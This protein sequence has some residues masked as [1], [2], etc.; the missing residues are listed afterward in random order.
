MV[1]ASRIDGFQ[2]GRLDCREREPAIQGRDRMILRILLFLLCTAFFQWG[3][4]RLADNWNLAP[5]QPVFCALS[6]QVL[7]LELARVLQPSQLSVCNK[8]SQQSV[9]LSHVCSLQ[10]V[11]LKQ[12]GGSVLWGCCSP[13]SSLGA[14][15]K[16]KRVLLIQL[17]YSVLASVFVLAVSGSSKALDGF[18]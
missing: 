10:E 2:R 5:A 15:G 12:Y 3:A 7:I 14:G 4:R 17:L 6:W 16:C 8:E 13:Q 1:R 9:T 11:R 18:F